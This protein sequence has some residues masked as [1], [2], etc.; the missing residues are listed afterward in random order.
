CILAGSAFSVALRLTP[1]ARTWEA[2]YPVL[3]C[4]LWTLEAVLAP[5]MAWTHLAIPSLYM[6]CA[7][8]TLGV[9]WILATETINLHPMTQ[10]PLLPWLTLSWLDQLLQKATLR[11]ISPL[12]LWQP[13][14]DLS[15]ALG[16]THDWEQKHHLADGIAQYV[17]RGI[18]SLLFHISPKLI[19]LSAVFGVVDLAMVFAQP[20]LLRSLLG[21]RDNG[22]MV[23][24]FAAT[25]LGG[26]AEAHMKYQLRI[27]GIR[28]RAALTA[29]ICDHVLE[30]SS[31]NS[32]VGESSPDAS[33]LIEVDLP[34]IFDFIENYH[35]TWMLPLQICISMAAL[36]YLVGL[37]SV[38][39]GCVVPVLLL[40]LS[41]RI[42]HLIKLRMFEE[43]EAKDARIDLVGQVLRH[44]K[45]L[46]LTASQFF[47]QDRIAT[48]RE[49]E[50]AK[51]Q[52][53]AT[54]NAAIVFV[55]AIMPPALMLSCLGVFVFRG[56]KLT[57]QLVFPAL[58]FFFNI[59][60]SL[61]VIP[62]ISVRYQGSVTGLRRIRDF[63]FG[64]PEMLQPVTDG[65][66]VNQQE[67]TSASLPAVCQP[68]VVMHN[69]EADIP[70]D[71]RRLSGK[72]LLVNCS[73]EAGPGQLII[74]TG[75][76]GSGKSTVI[77][78][79][80]NS[81]QPLRGSV[82]VVGR[83]AYASQKP[84][85]M[86]GTVREN[87]LFGLPFD[88]PFYGRV[89]HAAALADDLRI[90]PEGD[91]TMLGGLGVA[92]SGGQ[93]SRLALARAIYARRE[94]VV[95]DDPLAA[96][97]PRVSKAL[98]TNVLGPKGILK[99]SIRIV[100]SSSESLLRHADAVYIVSNGTLQA[101]T[102][103]DAI[104]ITSLS[105]KSPSS[106]DSQSSDSRDTLS[107]YG[108]IQSLKAGPVV[109]T[110]EID[111]DCEQAPLLNKPL[112]AVA[113]DRNEPV[114]LRH[115]LRFMK[116]ARPGGWPLV[117][118]LASSAKLLDVLGVYFL[119]LATEAFESSGHGYWHKLAWFAACG[120][121]SACLSACFVMAAYLFCLIPVGR[122][123]HS[124]LTAGVLGAH[125][126]FF[127][128]TPIGQMLNRF[129]NDMQKMDNPVN[130]GFLTLTGI[131]ISSSSSILVILATSLWS[132]L[133]LGPVG[134][135]YAA[136]QSYYLN[137]CQQLRRLENV[138]RGPVL[139]AVA[140]MHSGADLILSF[141][142][143]SNFKRRARCAIDEHT[144]VW[145]PF[146]A[147]DI[148][149]LL[150]LQLLASLVQLMSAILLL[151]LASSPSTLGLVMNFVIQ[152]TSQFNTLVQ[153]QATLKADFTSVVRI[154]DYAS[155]EP[156]SDPKDEVRPPFG[157]P[158]HPTVQFQ[159]FTM[160][161][162]AGGRPCLR[163]VNVSVA[164]G[165]HIA[166]VGRTGAGKS[167]LAQ[168][169]LRGVGSD[170]IRTGRV[171]VDGV[172][173]A[174]LS[175]SDVRKC[176]T[177]MPQDPP[178]L[179][180]TLRANL[181]F[182]GRRS[183]DEVMAVI[184]ECQL[185][186]MLNIASNQDPLEFGIKASG[187]NLSS[188]QVQALAL[189]RAL[190]SRNSLVILDEGESLG[191]HAATLS[192]PAGAVAH[193]WPSV[194]FVV[195]TLMLTPSPLATGA[196]SSS[197]SAA[198]EAMVRAKLRDCSVLSIT[199]NMESAVR[200]STI[201]YFPYYGGA[202][203]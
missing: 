118:L 188:G 114:S 165:D 131:L 156:E 49:R 63:L 155:L 184:E 58:A 140:E 166:V 120:V 47:F 46:K 77:K 65:I 199:H 182:E 148:W 173:I 54:L 72:P 167:S 14:T 177:L 146:L 88:A 4:L 203:L 26:F 168:A 80:I 15:V 175:L 192:P 174:G 122:T 187:T 152:I 79:L 195:A 185:R 97:D 64:D 82:K 132:T 68:S 189:A 129:T 149:L 50:L 25:L 190:L 112:P 159:S 116:M 44:A 5:A 107:D 36:V 103:S 66:Q 101:T 150:R 10:A 136:V 121:S 193:T 162:Q 3:S 124:Q 201:H 18:S 40:P 37:E 27:V 69:C 99:D 142:Q 24:L 170:A 61:A 153:T 171:L 143:S 1:C 62:Q 157:W 11:N 53:I 102:V 29:A 139:N 86:N 57:S 113:E 172:D 8:A 202:F 83:V 59:N 138:A 163:N 92:L 39:A 180:G 181:D 91:A 67:A 33:V 56:G 98:I 21:N 169:L 22:S 12:D 108:T 104:S 89:I 74:L 183:D 93:K 76:V 196:M 45:Q 52:R 28:L 178:I 32:S 147:L 60:R 42:M 137:T 48:T 2:L 51:V 70:G 85:L 135:L 23:G 17:P 30:P 126:R 96:V 158:R 200:P 128:I 73:L 41:A 111:A 198:V 105:Q 43:M 141:G 100:T 130:G 31:P 115:Y 71:S 133:Y 160:S 117:I 123:V 127:D 186:Q 7:I 55:T 84:F 35:I 13:D 154:W 179:T 110:D 191:F 19:F 6:A 161:Y 194:E 38:L 75:P 109:T 16:S 94:V 9:P 106:I 81:F 164:A 34:H 144:K 87:I 20:F 90:F 95:L 176:I 119:K 134:I 197:E 125:L 151:S 78:M 145:A